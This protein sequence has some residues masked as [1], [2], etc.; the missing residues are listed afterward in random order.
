M[1]VLADGVVAVT[2]I[3]TLLGGAI[4]FVWNKIERRFDEFDDKLEQCHSR[5][6]DSQERGVRLLTVIELLF[7]EV[8]RL[9]PDAPVLKRARRLLENLKEE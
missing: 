6:M 5:E 1:G 2:G 7:Q 4:G 9:S 8:A 3:S